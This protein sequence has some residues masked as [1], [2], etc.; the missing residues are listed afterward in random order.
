MATPGMPPQKEP[1]GGDVRDRPVNDHR[2]ARRNDG[3]DGRGRCGDG[4]RKRGAVAAPDHGRDQDGAGRGRVGRGRP[5]DPG[6]DHVGDHHHV[7]EAAHDVADQFVREIDQALGDPAAVHQFARQDEKRDRQQRKGVHRDEHALRHHRER[8]VALGDQRRERADSERE[9]ERGPH[10]QEDQQA[11]Q[12]DERHRSPA[13]HSDGKRNR[14]TISSRPLTGRTV[15]TSRK[16]VSNHAKTTTPVF[17]FMAS[18]IC[19]PMS[20]PPLRRRTAVDIPF[21]HVIID[22]P[23]E[24]DCPRPRL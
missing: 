16:M 3:A 13:L 10:E 21:C 17:F 7:R 19:C 12:Q 20:Q 1:T 11:E 9:R 24:N 18:I 5:G 8:D 23:W 2:D 22:A 4:A 15:R 14:C 6:H